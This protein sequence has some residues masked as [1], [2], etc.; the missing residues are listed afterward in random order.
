MAALSTGHRAALAALIDRCPER[1]LATLARV[2]P[3]M[4]GDKAEELSA[5][6]QAETAERRRRR[7]T[8]APLL[9]LFQ[10]RA[11][12]VEHLCFPAGVLPRLWVE[13]IGGDRSL[14]VILDDEEGTDAEKVADRL[15]RTAAGVVRDRPDVVWPPELAPEARQTG[16]VELAGCLDLAHLARGGVRQLPGWLNG[17]GEDQIA[18]LRLLL[19]DAAAVAPDGAARMIEI[20]F[21]HLADAPAILRIVTQTSRV[22]AREDFLG[23][24]ELADFVARII[25]AVRRRVDRVSGFSPSGDGPAVEAVVEDVRWCADALTQLDITLERDPQGDWSRDIRAARLAMAERIGVWIKAGERALAEAAPRTRSRTGGRSSRQ[26]AEVDRAV[27]SGVVA[28]A[29][30]WAR[31]LAALRGP[32]AVFGAEADR[33]TRV[34]ALV[35]ELSDWADQAILAINGGEVA[36]EAQAL[37]RVTDV[38]GLLE[39]LDA[40]EP[41]RTVRR[42]VAVAGAGPGDVGASPGSL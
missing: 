6:L 24:S 31:L 34:E 30:G 11:D 37:D 22:A 35:T 2:V 8:F 40:A 29:T 26:E 18:G 10:P 9:P 39:A 27:E 21:A 1:A 14:L 19:K 17:Q 32:A 20:L 16:L 13:A 41:A 7:L 36:N 28:S 12:G 23:G 25:R 42:R 38:A 4:G 15:C 3:Q 33:R 5:M